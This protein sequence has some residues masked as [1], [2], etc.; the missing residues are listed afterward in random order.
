MLSHAII[1]FLAAGAFAAPPP[2]YAT[3]H[4]TAGPTAGPTAVSPIYPAAETADFIRLHINVTAGQA[5]EGAPFPYSD[6]QNINALPSTGYFGRATG[7]EFCSGQVIFTRLQV[8]EPADYYLSPVS[9]TNSSLTM[10]RDSFTTHSRVLHI[11][12]TG[13]ADAQGRRP[14]NQTECAGQLATPGLRVERE[15]YARLTYEDKGGVSQR[16]SRTTTLSLEAD[17]A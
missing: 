15:P 16:D 6:V 12:S 13:E 2:A 9:A 1:P 14:V 7:E 17:L 4:A 11:A 3:S 10:R 5:P 8:P